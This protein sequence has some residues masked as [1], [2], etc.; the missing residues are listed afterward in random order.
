MSS[1]VQAVPGQVAPSPAAPPQQGGGSPPPGGGTPPK[2]DAQPSTPATPQDASAPAK[3]ATPDPAPPA[4]NSL[5]GGG[6][7]VQ[8]PE[9]TDA[10]QRARRLQQSANMLIGDD[11]GGDKFAGDKFFGDKIV[12]TQDGR[13]RLSLRELGTD[14]STPARHAFVA[15]DDWAQVRAAQAGKRIMILR[16][17]ANQGKVAAA[18]RL[19]QSPA[20]RP[21]FNLD[22][23][24]GLHDLAA[25]LDDYA[26]SER[27]LP[28]GAGILLCEPTAWDGVQGWM[29]QQLAVVL[30]H[31]DAQMVLTLSAGAAL[32]DQE[33]RDF[34]VDLGPAR[35]R[36]EVFERHLIWRLE[37][38]DLARRVLA[39]SRVT[40]LAGELL[41]GDVSMKVAADL[42]VTVSQALEGSVID[43][44]KVRELMG[45]RATED[46]DIWFT[47][48]PDVP[49]HCLA[50]ALAVLNGLPYETVVRA[51]ERLNDRLDGPPDV[52]PGDHTVVL[53]P[54]R[55]PF[56]R[57]RREV[58]RLLRAVTRPE[59]VQGMFGSAPVEIIGY[60]AKEY[61]RL[62]L[63]H[64][65]R[66]FR[67]HRELLGW[68]LDLASDTSEE[69]RTWAGT[70]LGLLSRS[71]FDFVYTNVLRQMALDKDNARNREVVAYALRVPAQDSRLRPLVDAVVTGLYGNRDSPFGQATA[72]RVY[73]ISLGPA[74]VPQALTALDRLATIDHFHIATSIGDSLADLIM[75]DELRNPPLVL[76]KVSTWQND[77]RRALVGELVFLQLARSL[78]TECTVTGAPGRPD[79]TMTWPTLLMLADSNPDL[80]RGLMSMWRHVLNSGS[81]VR[82]VEIALASWADLA[83][84]DADVR[85]SLSRMLAATA[86]QSDRTRVLVKRH[87][88][89][90]RAVDNLQPKPKTAYAVEAAL[91]SRNGAP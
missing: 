64:V 56:R 61:P 41:A 91:D 4:P 49:M 76:D 22:K 51:A 86:A 17:A 16:A 29:L 6:N 84:V 15:P 81:F 1:P 83:E 75:Q 2:G 18:I 89:G 57:S 67:L 13:T 44:G 32:A 79:R 82:A 20:D 63:E 90:W 7:A 31:L 59:T 55:D 43:V 62:V 27:R 33:I 52:V 8:P 50:I 65:W 87:V 66:E 30:E 46:F 9:A 70:A 19:L 54:W 58:L 73:G 38:E 11:V 78:T 74:D 26:K 34:V 24:V 5:E 69:V 14:L 47:G 21:I 80:R 28:S 60:T 39:D 25:R 45:K 77:R 72:A 37:D 36:I 48:L 68:L 10:H 88:A 23:D 71:A 40:E 53:P 35:P 85:I 12:V 3:P 42:A